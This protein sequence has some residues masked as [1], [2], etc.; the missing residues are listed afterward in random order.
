[1]ETTLARAESIPPPQG[2]LGQ[3][4]E[5][6]KSK[7]CAFLTPPN[8]WTSDPHSNPLADLCLSLLVLGRILD[9]KREPL[10]VLFLRKG[11]DPVCCSLLHFQ[12]NFRGTHRWGSVTALLRP[13]LVTCPRGSV[14]CPKSRQEPAGHWGWKAVLGKG[15]GAIL[16]PSALAQLVHT[17]LGSPRSHF[18]QRTGEYP[19]HR[20]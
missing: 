5:P 19:W 12:Q 18:P 2:Y 20:Q 3:G 10:R 6:T 16:P 1:M 14:S 13:L 7:P 8:F 11:D 17:G 9:V 4:K 15:R